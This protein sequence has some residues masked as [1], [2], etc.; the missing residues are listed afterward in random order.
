M[1]LVNLKIIMLYLWLRKTDRCIYLCHLRGEDKCSA[2]FGLD[3]SNFKRPSFGITYRRNGRMWT[4]HI[5][6]S[7]LWQNVVGVNRKY[8]YCRRRYP[9]RRALCPISC[10]SCEATFRSD[11][12]HE[13][14]IWRYFRSDVLVEPLHLK[15]SK[16]CTSTMG[17]ML[18]QVRYLFALADNLCNEI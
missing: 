15:E 5:L 17:E 7:T 18:I 9:S 4:L 11:C 10:T 1:L 8:A 16:T 12:E 6:K 13:N 14:S 3:L 2:K